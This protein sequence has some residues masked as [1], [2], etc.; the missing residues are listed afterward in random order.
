MPGDKPPF[1]K[2]LVANRG[3]IALRV[4]RAARALGI[5]TVAVY[6]EIDAALP[7]V[8]LADEAHCI[9]PAPASESYLNIDRMLD[10]AHRSHADAVHPGYG[11][12]AEIKSEGERILEDLGEGKALLMRNHGLL[13]VGRSIGE[14]FAFMHRLVMAC[15]TQVTILSMGVPHTEIPKEVCEQT[16]RQMQKGANEELFGE[17]MWPAYVRLAD[18]LDPSYRE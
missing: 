1:A 16:Y 10:I 12:L 3:E 15:N 11:F 14:A 4:I 9:G 17:R 7:H 13:T 18:R 8:R 6:S 5:R 2:L